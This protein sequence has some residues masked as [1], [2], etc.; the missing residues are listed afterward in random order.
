MARLDSHNTYWPDNVCLDDMEKY[1]DEEKCK[2]LNNFF[3]KYGMRGKIS[4]YNLAIIILDE[5]YG[6]QEYSGEIMD[7]I[8]SIYNIL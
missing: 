3:Q 6:L 4:P 5:I 1:M 8:E 2:K 7:I